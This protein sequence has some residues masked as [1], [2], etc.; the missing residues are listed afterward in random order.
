MNAFSMSLLVT[1]ARAVE[2]AD[3]VNVF[4]RCAENAELEEFSTSSLK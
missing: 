3:D 2:R 1:Y 4:L